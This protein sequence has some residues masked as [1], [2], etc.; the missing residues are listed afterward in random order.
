[1]TTLQVWRD[2]PEKS[3]LRRVFFRIHFWV[4]AIVGAYIL[5][6]SVSGS[7]IVFR[8]ELVNHGVSVE[9]MVRLHTNLPL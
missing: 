4:G 5:M 2:H 8:N 6:I 7:V 1:M 9:W 3:R